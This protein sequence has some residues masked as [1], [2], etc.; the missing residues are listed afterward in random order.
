[1]FCGLLNRWRSCN[2]RI[3]S[4]DDCKT[5]YLEYRKV[6]MFFDASEGS[7]LY[8]RS[9]FPS[10]APDHSEP[11]KVMLSGRQIEQCREILDAHLKHLN[12]ESDLDVL[13]PGASYES[14]LIYRDKE[15]NTFNHT[16]THVKRKGVML[17]KDR[18][19]EHFLSIFWLFESFCDVPAAVE[20]GEKDAEEASNGRYFEE[21]IW[22]CSRCQAANLMAHNR[23]VKC[24]ARRGELC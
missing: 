4:G 16:N 22:M 18:E 12:F 10:H 7:V 2:G 20:R 23:C 19:S 15:D 3:F 14:L 5:V 24:G 8:G 17:K 11:Q 9:S 21:T 13:P 6:Y 1:M